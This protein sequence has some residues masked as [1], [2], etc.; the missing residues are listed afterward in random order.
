MPES[1]NVPVPILVKPP[2]TPEMSPEKFVLVLSLPVLT[3][4]E[5][6]VTLPPPAS[7]P[8]V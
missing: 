7:E 8:M 3:V 4:A 6:S 2:P 1:V 5:P